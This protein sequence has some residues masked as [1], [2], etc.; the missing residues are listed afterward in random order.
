MVAKERVS[1]VSGTATPGPPLSLFPFQNK[2]SHT[3]CM[4]EALKTAMNYVAARAESAEWGGQGLAAKG[5]E[6]KGR[7]KKE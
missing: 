4:A 1:C 2:L 5:D 7:R 3:F 6:N